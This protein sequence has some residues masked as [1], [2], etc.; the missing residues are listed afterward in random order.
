MKN[1]K[2]ISREQL[3]EV[4]GGILP[5]MKRCYDEATCQVTIYYALSMLNSPCA[6]DLPVCLPPQD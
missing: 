5:G 3:K 6:T 2:K 1:L 4:K